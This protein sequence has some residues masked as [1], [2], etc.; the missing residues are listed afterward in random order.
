MFFTD[1]RWCEGS[2]D[3]FECLRMRSRSMRKYA[4]INAGDLGSVLAVCACAYDPI[5]VTVQG[6]SILKNCACVLTPCTYTFMWMRGTWGAVGGCCFLIGPFE[7][8]RKKPYVKYANE[9]MWPAKTIGL[10]S[11]LRFDWL[12]PSVGMYTANISGVHG[13]VSFKVRCLLTRV[14]FGQPLADDWVLFAA[15]PYIS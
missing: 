8:T 9:V 5:H 7:V 13:F 2:G 3:S 11:L 6:K 10:L 14:Y 4:H 12:G 1:F 15:S